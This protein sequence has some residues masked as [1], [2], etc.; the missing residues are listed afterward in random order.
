MAPKLQ[1]SGLSVLLLAITLILSWWIAEKAHS[2]LPKANNGIEGKI[3]GLA[4]FD[5][6]IGFIQ[7]VDAIFYTS[8]VILIYNRICCQ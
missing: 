8:E 5:I 1:N 3:S 7:N 2:H 6:L 4:P